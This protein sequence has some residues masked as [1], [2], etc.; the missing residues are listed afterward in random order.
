MNTE[1][2]VR[3]EL[4][5]SNRLGW[6]LHDVDGIEQEG[7][8][9]QLQSASLSYAGNPGDGYRPASVDGSLVK[10]AAGSSLFVHTVFGAGSVGQYYERGFTCEVDLTNNQ[11]VGEAYVCRDALTIVKDR[12]DEWQ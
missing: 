6:E 8:S 4:T 12:L 3:G 9:Y 1:A 5:S 11:V 7:G 2:A 10:V